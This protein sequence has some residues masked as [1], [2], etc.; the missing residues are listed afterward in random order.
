[1]LIG[2]CVE[3][4]KPH[5]YPGTAQMFTKHAPVQPHARAHPGVHAT[6]SSKKRFSLDRKSLEW[7]LF[8][9]LIE[10][11]KNNY[12]DWHRKES[13]DMN[14]FLQLWY[15]HEHHAKTE[16]FFI[17]TEK[18]LRYQFFQPYLSDHDSERRTTILKGGILY[19]KAHYAICPAP[20]CLF[21]KRFC[22]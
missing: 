4:M 2:D 19:E 15:S 9:T 8:N 20:A 12:L 6:R 16:M 11:R 14:H 21:N 22:G 18:Y 5:H 10:T 17:T 3:T 13:L 1:M 7:K